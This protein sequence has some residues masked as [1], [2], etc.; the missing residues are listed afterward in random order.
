MPFILLNASS[1]SRS[2]RSEVYFQLSVYKMVHSVNEWIS[3]SK[4]GTNT[5]TTM[6]AHALPNRQ[7]RNPSQ[8]EM[9][10]FE[11]GGG[12]P[13]RKPSCTHQNNIQ[14]VYPAK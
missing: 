4:G 8:F 2:Q 12:S 1:W 3:S 6:H 9:C 10:L 13:G 11:L 14:I 5:H 7:F